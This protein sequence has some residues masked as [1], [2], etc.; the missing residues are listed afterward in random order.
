M[1]AEKEGGQVGEESRVEKQELVWS[2]SAQVSELPLAV[3]WGGGRIPG[4]RVVS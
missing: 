2:F 1:I 4:K 3:H